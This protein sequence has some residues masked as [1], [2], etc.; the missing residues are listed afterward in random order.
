MCGAAADAVFFFFKLVPD[1]CFHI[2]LWSD[3][4]TEL[5]KVERSEGFR[6]GPAGASH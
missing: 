5:E 2:S 4:Q 1:L 6:G 3:T